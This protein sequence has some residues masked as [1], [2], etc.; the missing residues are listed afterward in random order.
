VD[1]HESEGVRRADVGATVD[2]L[3]DTIYIAIFDCFEE[4]ELRRICACTP[5]PKAK[6]R[7]TPAIL[8]ASLRLQETRFAPAREQR[9]RACASCVRCRKDD[10][11]RHRR[12]E[13]GQQQQEACAKA[14]H[15]HASATKICAN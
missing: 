7:R 1:G 9:P 13:D 3:F 5:A 8:A 14:P 2:G 11:R 6:R 12:S 4:A 15:C 10:H